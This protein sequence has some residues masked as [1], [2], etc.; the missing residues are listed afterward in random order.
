MQHTTYTVQP[1]CQAPSC[2]QSPDPHSVP[3]LVFVVVLCVITQLLENYFPFQDNKT[4]NSDHSEIL[5]KNKQT[6]KIEQPVV[7]SCKK[8]FKIVS[9]T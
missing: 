3:Y 7:N 5:D 9:S 4:L 6:L 2:T 1:S 8:M